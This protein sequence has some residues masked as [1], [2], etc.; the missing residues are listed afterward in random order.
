MNSQYYR[1][2]Q[3][4]DFREEC[5]KRVGYECERCGKKDVILQ[6]H[7][8]E[9]VNGKKPWEYSHDFCEVLC[10]GCHA[11]E[12]GIILPKEGWTVLCS[13]LDNNEPSEPVPCAN[14]GIDVTWHFVI[15]HPEWGETIV[16][17]ECAENL[18]LGSEVV[19][20][21]SYQ[22][23]MKTFLNSPRW[24]KT[25]RGWKILH[26]D[27]SALVFERNGSYKI[28]INDDWGTLTFKTPNEAKQR[29]FEVIESRIEK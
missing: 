23:R 4:F 3:W 16:G 7:H 20:M 2:H 22:R 24:S 19:R 14:C 17:S 21:K 13:D 29:V 12:H 8:P 27:Y 1:R 28:K 10:R 18:S 15:Y 5:L 9:Y 25:P 11:I 26:K 6:V